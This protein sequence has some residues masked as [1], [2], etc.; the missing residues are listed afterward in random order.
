MASANYL[1]HIGKVQLLAYFVHSNSDIAVVGG[2]DVVGKGNL[3]GMRVI[4][5]LSQSESF[6]QS[7]TAGIDYKDFKENVLLGADRSTAP[8]QYFPVTVG[9]RGDWTED[10]V[11]SFASFNATFGIRGLGDGRA[12]FDNKRY[13]AKPDFFVL[14][15]EADLLADLWKGFQLHAHITG[16]YS[17]SPLVSNEEFSLGGSDTVRGYD[18]SEDLGDYGY[19]Y[20]FELRSPR[21]FGHVPH[22]DDLRL[23]AFVDSGY[24]GI[25]KP[26]AGQLA[27]GF[28]E[29][30]GGGVRIK[31][32]K[33]WNGSVDVGVPLKDGPDTASGK[34][35][36]RFRIWGEF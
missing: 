33:I 17:D 19:A 6:Y 15:S 9:W 29:S 13:E 34:V 32:F 27:S 23:L 22:L 25:H 35:F 14:K 11:K 8:I 36:A 3:A 12:A 20:Q 28:L 21:L 18:E 30:V 1:S 7:L 4:V 26:L 2:T 31:L 5:P 24:W 16:Q 10:K